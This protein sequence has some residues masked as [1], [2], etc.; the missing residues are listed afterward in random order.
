M[1]WHRF[2]NRADRDA[3]T[4][5]DIRFYLD[6]ETEDN[7][8]RGMPPEEAR[9]AAYRKLGNSALIREEIYGMGSLGFAET[10]WQDARY[11]LRTMRRNPAFAL[12]AALTLALGIGANTAI[13][14]VIRAVLLNPLAYPNPGR[15]V[16]LTRENPRAN[17][18][19]DSFTLLRFEKMKASARSFSGIGAYLKLAENMSLSGRGEPVALTGARVSANFLDILGVQ[20]VTGRGFLPEEDKPG[21]PPVAIISS[22]LWRRRFESDPGIAGKAAILDS[23][24]YTIIGVAPEGF[25]FPFPGID[26][27]ITRPEAWSVLA[28]QFWPYVTLLNGFARLKPG[29]SIEQAQAEIDV[30][31]RQYL[32]AH[33]ER[34]DA[35]PGTGMRVTS[36]KDRLV[37]NVRPTLWTLFGAVVFVLLIA[38]ANVASL[39]LA[40]ASARSREF[41][42]RAAVGAGRGRLVRQLLV[43]SLILAIVGGAFGTLLANWALHAMKHMSALD[44]PR[45]AEIRL[46]GMVL[47][48]T[49]ALSVVT[50]ILFGLFPSLQASRPDLADALRESGA[51]AGRGLS[52]RGGVLGVSAHGLLVIGQVA[53]SIVLLIGAALLMKSFA[54]LH[55]IDPGFQPANL[56]TMKIALPPARYD[57]DQKKSAFFR[58]LA[59]HVEATPG[60]RDA[61]VAMS[62]P[63]TLGWLGTNVSA[64]GQPLDDGNRNSSSARLQSITP[65]YFRTLG[66]P[67]RRGRE[68][69]ARDNAPGAPQ[70]VIVNE[71]FA[72]RFWPAYPRG[73]NPVGQHMREGID[74][75]DWMRIV[76]IVADVRELGPTAG[77]EPEFYVPTTIHAPQTAYLA[78]RTPGDPLRFANAV[79]NQVLSID[80]DQPVSEVKTMDDVLDST[81]GQRRLT[82]LLLGAFA[83]LALLLSVIGIYGVIAYSVSRRTQEL[84]IRQAL[85]AGQADILRLVLRQGLVLTLAG[86]AIGIGGALALTRVIQGLLFHVSATDPAT[87][88]GIAVLFVVVALA[89]SYIPARRAARIDPMAALRAE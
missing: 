76:G 13:F 75:T 6:T 81:L 46:D 66:I 33:P 85:G 54:R 21:A 2:F 36:L 43:E 69:T 84:G 58:E 30:L 37:S 3:E 39:L 73:L 1:S 51:A 87:F 71:S 47:G 29:V 57:T 20:P 35:G 59:Q 53:L 32:R 26:V 60:V 38:C 83:G 19:N 55:N 52:S 56:L 41:A 88:A 68:F 63:T 80:S 78:V 48:F 64:E 4:A 11:A 72:R 8:A 5:R 89:A 34:L 7:I 62:L 25:A 27:W 31:N 50:G 79:R 24:P 12:T 44:L 23:T 77:A 9:A 14:T 45:A 82:M 28:P 65:G 22:G 86:V 67:L 15:L 61:T 40:R 74:H 49:V 70:V 42:V 18:H 16:R 17:A 10:L